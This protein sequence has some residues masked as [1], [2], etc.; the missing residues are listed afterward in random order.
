MIKTVR[1]MSFGGAAAAALLASPILAAG[2]ADLFAGKTVTYIVATAPGGGYDTYGRLVAEFMQ[3]HLTGSSFVVKN[4]VGA[5]G[6]IGTAAV[7]GAK[8]DGTTVGTFNI[9]MIYSQLVKYEGVK[10]ELEKMS[11]IGK[12]ASDSRVIVLST[13]SPIKTF[14]DLAAQKT[15]VNFAT[16]GV[17]GNLYSE[18]KMVTTALHLPINIIPGYNGNDDQM[19]MRRNEV[20]GALGSRSSF[21]DFVRNGYARFVVQIGGKDPNLPQL[22]SF[23]TDSQAKSLIALIASQGELSR[24]TAGPPNIPQD[25]LNALR[26]AFRQAMEDKELQARAAKLNLPLDPGYGADV[27][28]AVRAALNQTPETVAM[29]TELM[30]P[31][32]K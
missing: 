1:W 12:A 16:G 18:T 24:L 27:H 19:A 10:F 4:V 9:G 23:A 17:G 25:R 30:K 2:P 26:G 20:A 7:Y 21:D 29:I 6:L 3:K 32:K 31:D 5:G 22:S 13:T 14:E 8:P 11:W 28:S 15:P